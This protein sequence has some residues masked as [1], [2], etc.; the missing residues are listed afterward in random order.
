MEKISKLLVGLFLVT[1]LFS[2]GE[3][4]TGTNGGKTPPNVSS[5]AK[6]EVKLDGKVIM[7]NNKGYASISEV[8]TGVDG[9]TIN[10][11]VTTYSR[12]P[13]STTDVPTQSIA[14]NKVHL[15]KVGETVDLVGNSGNAEVAIIKDFSNQEIY[16]IQKGTL[17]REAENKFSFTATEFEYYKKGEGQKNLT[18]N[19]TGYVISALIKKIGKEA[20]N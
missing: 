1:A 8:I 5:N 10:S 9:V 14:I 2:C 6:Y 11:S 16:S 17:T 19:L 18:G 12:I 7:K 3:D 13:K 4:N 15:L 20:D